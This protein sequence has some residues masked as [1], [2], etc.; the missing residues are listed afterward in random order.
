[1]YVLGATSL[2]RGRL[3]KPLIHTVTYSYKPLG[4]TALDFDSVGFAEAQSEG[5]IVKIMHYL[6]L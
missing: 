5:E 4:S 1:M 6:T 2:K 3:Y